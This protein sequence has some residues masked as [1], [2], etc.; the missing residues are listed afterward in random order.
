[1][2][3][4]DIRNLERRGGFC[5]LFSFWRNNLTYV[6]D[7]MISISFNSKRTYVKH[8]AWWSSVVFYT[9]VVLRL[10][11]DSFI[12]CFMWSAIVQDRSRGLLD[13]LYRSSI[14]SKSLYRNITCI[15]QILPPPPHATCRI[16]PTMLQPE[17]LLRW[18]TRDGDSTRDS[19]LRLCLPD[20]LNS[21]HPQKSICLIAAGS[22][23]WR[24]Y[25]SKPLSWHFKIEVTIKPFARD[26]NVFIID[27]LEQVKSAKG[28]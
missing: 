16:R 9:L 18:C 6:N 22:F 13:A 4:C 1:M 19:G 2:T 5:S 21:F 11:T 10:I 20:L 27:I 7:R 14:T 8:V 17:P 26:D 23:K 12:S 3:Q 24:S 28:D 15:R 25:Y